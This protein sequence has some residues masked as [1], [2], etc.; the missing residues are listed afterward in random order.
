MNPQERIST[1]LALKEY[2]FTDVIAMV[3]IIGALEKL[4][5]NH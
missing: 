4:V 1:K 3:K 5:F 2:C